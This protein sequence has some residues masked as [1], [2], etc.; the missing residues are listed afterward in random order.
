MLSGYFDDSG[1]HADS[2]V[3]VWAGL[4]GTEA[5]WERLEPAWKAKLEEPLPGKAPLKQFHLSACAAADDEFRYYSPAE[6]DLVRHEF[7]T[8]IIEAGLLSIGSVVSRPDWD[9]LVVGKLRD[10]LGDAETP[11]FLNCINRGL[12][13]ARV[14][15]KEEDRIAF[16]FDEGRRSESLQ[17]LI[18]RIMAVE[19]REPP[20][21][22]S[23]L[24]N[25]VRLSPPLQAADTVATESFWAAQKWLQEGSNAE[26]TAHFK[27][28]LAN[29]AAEGLIADREAIL[30]TVAL[31]RRGGIEP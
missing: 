21:I 26:A 12:K 28:F 6:R 4:L 14:T 20:T 27:H 25:P 11:C 15:H 29:M 2:P 24:F 16:V 31:L 19:D 5:Q 10:R 22:S 7:R 23:I 30:E 1:T 9:E 13:L 18:D 3:V 17:T 8:L